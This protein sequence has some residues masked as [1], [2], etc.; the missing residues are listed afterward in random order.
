MRVYI[1]SP[2]IELADI[3]ADHLIGQGHTCY[4]IENLEKLFLTINN[5]QTLP[6]LL[7]LD[8]TSFNH[9]SFNAARNLTRHN[10][11]LPLIFY[12]DPVLTR[13]HRALHWKAQ[14]ELLQCRCG[15]QDLSVYD[16]IFASIQ[17]LIESKELRPYVPLMQPPKPLPDELKKQRFTLDFIRKNLQDT[18]IAFK[19]RTKLPESL[20]YLLQ[21]LQEHKK[22][23]MTLE[24][25]L[26]V[27]KKDG[28]TMKL[29]SLKVLMSRLRN[30]I[31]KDLNC[32]FLIL[33]ENKTYKFIMYK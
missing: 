8:Y 26:E 33:H 15:E 19:E 11:F 21:I 12:N 28:K 17:T 25:I 16:E 30:T 18:V 4:V 20:F 24:E 3:I 7:V 1:H 6:D 31:R 22:E 27:Y 10:K 9:D 13:S 2:L 23:D 29:E 5:Q 32:S 14:I